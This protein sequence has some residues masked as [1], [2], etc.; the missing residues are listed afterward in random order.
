MCKDSDFK[1][2]LALA[3]EISNATNFETLFEVFYDPLLG[4]SFSKDIIIGDEDMVTP[5][6]VSQFWCCGEMRVMQDYA[7]HK[8]VDYIPELAFVLNLRKDLDYLEFVK[9]QEVFYQGHRK[10]FPSIKGEDRCGFRVLTMHTHT[11]STYPSPSEADYDIHLEQENHDCT[12]NLGIIE[13][14]LAINNNPDIEDLALFMQR[15]PGNTNE[16][17]YSELID[18]LDRYFENRHVSKHFPYLASYQVIHSRG[19]SHESGAQLSRFGFQKPW[20]YT[21]YNERNK[22]I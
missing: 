17:S 11:N 3:G 21:P 15:K 20:W 6:Y 5:P 22:N 13:M 2:G 19:V 16:V 12:A 7:Y 18:G 10:S 9:K 1:A 4:F 14:I 8:G